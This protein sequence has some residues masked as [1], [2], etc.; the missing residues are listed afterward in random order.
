MVYLD[1]H[2][3]VS[4]GYCT[5]Q[6]VFTLRTIPHAQSTTIKIQDASIASYENVQSAWKMRSEDV[7][8][9]RH[10]HSDIKF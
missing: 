9:S 4:P 5:A 2:C 7:V 6:Q 8:A 1:G 3:A 10:T